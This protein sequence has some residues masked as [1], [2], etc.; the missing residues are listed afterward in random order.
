AKTIN[1]VPKKLPVYFVAG[2]DDPVGDY[3]KG[4]KKAYDK[5]VK[6]G[7]ED[8]S[9]TLYEGGRHEILNDDCKD[10]VLSDVLGFINAHIN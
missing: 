9:I 6:A 5:F 2:E 10:K 3:G 1:A 8:V 4:V 7:V